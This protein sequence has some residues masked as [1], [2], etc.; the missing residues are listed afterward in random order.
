MFETD[1]DDENDEDDDRAGSEAKNFARRL[2]HGL[3]HH[4]LHHDHDKQRDKVLGGS[5]HKR[6]VSD[7]GP[8]GSKERTGGSR[9]GISRTLNAA[10][11]YRRG[12]AAAEAA[13]SARAVVSMDLPRQQ[14]KQQGV[15][16]AERG[17]RFWSS[18]GSNEFLGR[19]LRRRG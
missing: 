2:M 13:D 19:I 18:R 8:S 4:H 12:G 7:D 9:M 6:S 11:R 1:S 10:T 16:E 14:Y 3:V 17:G 5:D 15:E